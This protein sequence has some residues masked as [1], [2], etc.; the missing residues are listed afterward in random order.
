MSASFQLHDGQAH[1]RRSRVSTSTRRRARRRRGATAN[2]RRS[3]RTPSRRGSR[4][5]TS[6]A[7]RS[8]RS[9]DGHRRSSVG[10]EARTIAAA[11]PSENK[12]I[13]TRLSIDSSPGTNV[14]E[15]ISLAMTSTVRSPPAYEIS[16]E[17][18]RRRAAERRQTEDGDTPHVAPQARAST[19]TTRR[20]WVS[21]RPS[22]TRRSACRRRRVARRREPWP[23]EPRNCRAR[24]PDRSRCETEHPAAADRAYHSNGR[25]R[26]RRSMPRAS[27]TPSPAHASSSG[28]QR[29]CEAATSLWSTVGGSDAA[30]ADELRRSGACSP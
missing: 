22:W 2:L 17:P 11:A 16:R 20:G 18:E 8:A 24:A 5:P 27:N 26:W 25:A 19:P 29:G 15:F 14:S 13:V 21:A 9:V 10:C 7:D 1:P 30:T 4:A 3:R 12:A 28:I 6:S 23:V